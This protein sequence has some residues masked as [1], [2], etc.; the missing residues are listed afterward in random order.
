MS[1]DN[2]EQRVKAGNAAAHRYGAS[3]VK[4]GRRNQAAIDELDHAI[5]TAVLMEAPVTVRG[6]FYRVVSAGAVDKT[7]LGYRAVGRRLLALRRSGR[8][9]YSHITDG[10]RAVFTPR[11]WSNVE[12]MLADAAVS[13]R[14]ALWHDSSVNV[15]VYTEKDAIT[16]VLRPITDA[17]DVPLG[18]MRGYC[19]ESFAWSVARGIADSGKEMTY[20]YQFGD[21]DPSGVGAWEDLQ[22]KVNAFLDEWYLIPDRV[23]T[24]ERL[25]VTPE[26][27][28]YLELPTRPT[29]RT[30]TRSRGFGGESVEVDAIPAELLRELAKEAI[31]SHIDPE[32]LRITEE[33]E[34]SEREVLLAMKNQLVEPRG[35]PR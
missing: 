6:V 33:A 16:G 25:A 11:T 8:V 34:R 1:T 15:L 14:R 28:E 27:I 35:E 29:K 24:F 23:M 26:Q 20:V 10:H 12:A 30:D 19:S 5:I 13:Y 18:V 21:H 32:R 31:T 4:R 7:E 17:W 2:H 9:D 22:H 3:T